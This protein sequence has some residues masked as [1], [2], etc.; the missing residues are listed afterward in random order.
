MTA[1]LVLTVAATAILLWG[2][3]AILR[4]RSRQTFR[5]ARLS[6]GEFLV[7]FEEPT[8]EEVAHV[9]HAILRELGWKDPEIEDRIAPVTAMPVD[10]M[11]RRRWR[12]VS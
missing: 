7:S 4:L 8:D 11:A 6:E 10:P 3:Q 1:G 9:A 5:I 12:R 2:L